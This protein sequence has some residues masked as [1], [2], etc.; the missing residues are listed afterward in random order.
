MTPQEF[1]AL[2]IDP[3]LN[4]LAISPT[5]I[6]RVFYIQIGYQINGKWQLGRVK[7]FT[8]AT[9]DSLF[10][11][12]IFF[13]RFM[14]PFFV[15]LQIRW[16]GKNPQAREYF[17]TYTGWK[18]N[19]FFSIAFRFQSDSSAAAGFTSP[20]YGQAISWQDGGK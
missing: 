15:S 13:C 9:D 3:W 16:A 17:Q 19:G 12:G 11:N 5:R 1:T 18:F 2:F 14:L 10:R 6:K 8:D 7:F 4:K 20:N